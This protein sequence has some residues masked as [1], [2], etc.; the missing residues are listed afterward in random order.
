ME[1][2]PSKETLENQMKS[3]EDWYK[4]LIFDANK[5]PIAMKNVAK[6]DDAELRYK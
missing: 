5:K 3:Q 2:S 4:V 6:V 1:S